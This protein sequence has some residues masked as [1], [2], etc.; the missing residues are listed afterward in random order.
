MGPLRIKSVWFEMAKTIFEGSKTGVTNPGPGHYPARF[1]C[2]PPNKP[3]CNNKS[4]IKFCTSLMMTI[5]CAG[6]WKYLKH[7]G[8][9]PSKNANGSYII[10]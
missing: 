7:A 2:I 8:L 6:R 4:V 5:R 3:N 10:N 1:K 9:Q